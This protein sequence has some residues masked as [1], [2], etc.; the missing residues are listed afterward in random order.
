MNLLQ[1]MLDAGAYERDAV[2]FHTRVKRYP[3]W[4]KSP[5]SV[6][7]PLVPGDHMSVRLCMGWR[8]WGFQTLAERD[9]FVMQF[10]AFEFPE[11]NNG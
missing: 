1:T 6:K 11:R 2:F 9:T 10:N 5:T 4:A 8:L 3:F 7:P